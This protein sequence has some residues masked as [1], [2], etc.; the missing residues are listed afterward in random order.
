LQEIERL[1]LEH[2][3][4]LDINEKNVSYKKIMGNIIKHTG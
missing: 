2:N 3:K 1:G 4:A